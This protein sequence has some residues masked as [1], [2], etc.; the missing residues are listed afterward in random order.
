MALQQTRKEVL[1][2]YKNLLRSCAKYPSKNR[3]GI[4]QAIK[5]EFRES[6]HL[7]PDDETTKK[8]I[9]VAIKGLSQLKMY[10]SHH[11]SGGNQQ[12]PNWSVQL[13]QNP[14]PKPDHL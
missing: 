3:W 6:T 2:L 5:E 10:D 1:Q 7:D 8:K 11:L 4:Y 14:M 13:E 9:S 12:N